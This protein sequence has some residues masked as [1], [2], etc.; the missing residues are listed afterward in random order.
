MSEPNTFE[1]PAPK[2]KVYH[3]ADKIAP[4][5][6]VSALCY[7]RPRPI[8]LRKASWTIRDEG[9]TCPKCLAEMDRRLDAAS[10]ESET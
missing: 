7:Q 3:R 1:G 9:V 5:G 4:N 10:S 2:A 6:D 8:D